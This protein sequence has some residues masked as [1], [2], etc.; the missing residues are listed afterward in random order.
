M[1]R[2]PAHLPD[3]DTGAR[4]AGCSTTGPRGPSFRAC[5]PATCTTSYTYD[6]RNRLVSQLRN[7]GAISTAYSLN[8]AGNILSEATTV[9]LT[10]TYNYVGGRLDTIVAGRHDP[11]AQLGQTV[12]GSTFPACPT[13]GLAQVGL[14]PVRSVV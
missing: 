3:L 12:S 10:K 14:S 8:P 5:Y 11:E 13:R 1:G 9:A 6:P 4:V 7:P 2:A